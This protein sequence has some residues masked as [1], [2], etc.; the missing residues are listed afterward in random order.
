MDHSFLLLYSIPH[1]IR[2]P[3]LVYSFYL[4]GHLRASQF[5]PVNILVHMSGE[6]I[7]TF[8]LDTYLRMEILG[9]RLSIWITLEDTA[10]KFSKVVAII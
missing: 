2:T 4:D 7:H 10:K 5:G 9:H 1:S 6:C 8:L 3:Q